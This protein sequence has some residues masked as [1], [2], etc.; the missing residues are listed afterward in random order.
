MS[1]LLGLLGLGLRGRL[2]VVGVDPVRAELQTGKIRCVV[3]A[4]DASPRAVAK[5]VRLAE[6]RGVPVVA[7][8]AAAEI[9]GRLGRPPVMVVGVR[10]R[11]LADG[12]LRAA[13]GRDVTED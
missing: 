1:G 2:V 12:I 9:G 6:G 8:P 4:S 11:G 13:P 7:G 3:L 5:V 10:D